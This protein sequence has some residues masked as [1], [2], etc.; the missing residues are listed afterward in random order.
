MLCVSSR[1]DP[2]PHFMAIYYNK[3]SCMGEMITE[4]MNLRLRQTLGRQGLGLVDN[5]NANLK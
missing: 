1:A 5:V 3:Y 4:M 2:W